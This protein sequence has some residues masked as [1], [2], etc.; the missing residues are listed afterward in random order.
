MQSLATSAKVC[1]TRSP[2]GVAET[3]VDRFEIVEVEQ[4]HRGR[5]RIGRLALE[6]RFAVLQ[7][8]AAVGDAGQRIDQRRGLV[9]VL[10]ALFRHR[11]QDEG[12]RDRE[13]QRLEAQHGEPDA[14]EHLVARS[15]TTAAS[16][17]TACATDKARRARTA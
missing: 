15:A 14:L 12:D 7:E 2:I 11:Q 5:T 16:R 17:R 3:I 8:G 4:H 9:A 10:G 1:S 6:L 13:Q